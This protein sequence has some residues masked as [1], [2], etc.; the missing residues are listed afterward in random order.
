MK[1]V[2]NVP[3]NFVNSTPHIQNIQATGFEI[4]V[5]MDK[6]GTVFYIVADQVHS[7]F[8]LDGTLEACMTSC[9][10]LTSTRVMWNEA[11]DFLLSGIS[12]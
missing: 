7:M 1:T 5:E 3:P 8:T 6:N 4:V 11:S 10:Q 12:S 2:D 9:A